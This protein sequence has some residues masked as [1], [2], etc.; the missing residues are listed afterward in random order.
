MSD[1]VHVIRRTGRLLRL[2]AA[3]VALALVALAGGYATIDAGLV[4]GEGERAMM[5]L[6]SILTLALQYALT[7][8]L[9]G[10]LGYGVTAR[11]RLLAFFGMS[12]VTVLTTAIGLLLLVVPGLI[13]LARWS[14]TL[15]LLL[16]SGEGVFAC[17]SRGF[18]ETRGRTSPILLAFLIIYAPGFA[19]MAGLLLAWDSLWVS[20]PETGAIGLVAVA[21]LALEASRIAGWYASVAI[22]TLFHDSPKLGEIFE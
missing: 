5:L 9:L 10:D 21:N 15:P 14:T 4:T 12:L 20:L 6:L 13:L 3:R 17:L 2:H 7:R 22:F 16:T 1:A 11:S 18:Q 8:A 19:A